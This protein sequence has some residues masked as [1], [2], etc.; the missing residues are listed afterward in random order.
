MI[1]I[2]K[3]MVAPAVLLLAAGA[4]AARAEIV[5]AKVPFD[6]V[7]RGETFP[8]GN[9]LLERDIDQ[10]EVLFIRPAAGGHPR[11]VVFTEPAGD[12]DPAGEQSALRFSRHGSQYWLDDVWSSRDE[13]WQVDEGRA[14]RR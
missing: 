11:V 10:P 12:R 1:R 13:G 6:F 3:Q 14:E 5:Q 4:G 8:A 7:V 9:Y 2:L